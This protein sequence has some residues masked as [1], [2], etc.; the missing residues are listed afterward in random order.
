[1]R[2]VF[3]ILSAIF[4]ALLSPVIGRLIGGALV[5][6]IGELISQVFPAYGDVIAMSPTAE[7]ILASVPASIISVV[8]YIFFF[9][10][11]HLLML[12]PKHIITKQVFERFFPNMPKIRWAGALC[13]TIAGV[14]MFVC[15]TAPLCGTLDFVGDVGVTVSSL[16][17]KDEDAQGGEGFDIYEDVIE[18]TSNNFYVK[19]TS[20]LGGRPIYN[21]L[22]V[23]KID[24]EKVSVSRELDVL[25]DVLSS[26]KPMMGEKGMASLKRENIDTLA[27]ASGRLPETKIVSGLLADILSGAAKKWEAGESFLGISVSAGEGSSADFLK[28]FLIAFKGT[29]K[30]TVGEDIGTLAGVLGILYDNGMLETK[31]G[32]SMTDSLKNDGFISKLLEAVMKNERFSGTAASIINLGVKSTLDTL[33][34]PENSEAVY[35]NFVSDVA[36]IV[37]SQP[38]EEKLLQKTYDSFEAHGVKTDKRVTDL[39]ASYLDKQFGDRTDV[40]SEEMSHIAGILQRQTGPVNEQ[41]LLDCI[42]T[43]QDEYQSTKVTTDEDLRLRQERMKQRK[44]IKA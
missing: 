40:T 44:G 29:T 25:A 14:A 23:L 12:I 19:F 39:T 11:F 13:G 42:R 21:R 30:A 31:N 27:S 33:G 26:V 7:A 4:A 10:I 8:L 36:N 35:D 2:I 22:T 38:S 20:V 17:Q 1:M 3:I 16:A 24:G 43:I 28:E 41:A 5:S 34:V 6:K 37:N 32:A 15:I 9:I 18:P